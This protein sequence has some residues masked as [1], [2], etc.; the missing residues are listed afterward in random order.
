PL[1]VLPGGTANVLAREIGLPLNIP[2]AARLIPRSSAR[3][4][5]LGQAGSRYFL[6][7]AGVGFDAGI[8]F[9]VD[10]R[11]K[12]WLG[13]SA[14]VL[15]ALKHALLFPPAP[16][17]IVTPDGPVEAAFACISKSQY[18]G[19]LR[20][21][22]EADLFSDCFYIYSFHPKNRWRYFVYA[23]ALLTNNLKRLPD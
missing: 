11:L 14:Y 9:R 4:V 3:R 15:E 21:V 18:Y 17:V 10:A 22:R 23:A 16:F 13:M 5:A 2:A 20:M 12:R 8:V 6:L 19:P 7:M 1:A